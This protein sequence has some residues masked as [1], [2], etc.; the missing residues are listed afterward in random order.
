MDIL[1]KQYY[2]IGDVAEFIGVPVTTIRYWEREF[3]EISPA[4]KSRGIRYY[5]PSDIETLRIINYLLKTKGLKIE[6]AK[7]QMQQNK[8][9]ISK[10]IKVLDHLGEVR[11]ELEM[12]LK[13]LGKRKN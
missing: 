2:R 7:L 4:R 1:D 6:A 13:S 12:L 10:R 8:K 5:S 3:P 11:S 9:N